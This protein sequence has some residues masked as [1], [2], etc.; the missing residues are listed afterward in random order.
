MFA[1]F[2]LS[3]G[4]VRKD[5]AINNLKKMDR[6]RSALVYCFTIRFRLDNVCWNRS[7]TKQNKKRFAH[8]DEELRRRVWHANN[9]TIRMGL[10][11]C[12]GVH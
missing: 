4:P 1:V 12:F 9:I 2:R 8:N 5:I 3:F 6:M 11:V 7:K 10:C